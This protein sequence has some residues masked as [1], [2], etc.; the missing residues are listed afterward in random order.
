VQSAD[1]RGAAAIAEKDLVDAVA[2]GAGAAH[3]LLRGAGRRTSRVARRCALNAGAAEA[4]R[5]F[6]A[7]AGRSSPLHSVKS[8]PS[9]PTAPAV[10]PRQASGHL[11]S[12]HGRATGR[13]VDRRWRWIRALAQDPDLDIVASWHLLEQEVIRYFTTL[14][15]P[16]I[17][18]RVVS[19]AP[20]ERKR[21]CS[22]SFWH[23]TSR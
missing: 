22:P 7:P 16:E 13:S 3:A 2:R 4:G 17:S 23:E 10:L 11:T 5:G 18:A 1:A 12:P 9:S 19:R 8:A 14:C 6:A 21:T 20:A 15:Y